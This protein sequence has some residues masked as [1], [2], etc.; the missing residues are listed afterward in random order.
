MLSIRRLIKNALK[1]VLR[2]NNLKIN[3][4]ALRKCLTFG[5]HIFIDKT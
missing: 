1:I 5:V 2:K 4:Y 3:P